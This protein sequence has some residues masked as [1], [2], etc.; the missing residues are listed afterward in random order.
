M[1]TRKVNYL[2]TKGWP[3]LRRKRDKVAYGITPIHL[4]PR[5]EVSSCWRFHQWRLLLVEITLIEVES[6]HISFMK[7]HTFINEFV[8]LTWKCKLQTIRHL[9]VKLS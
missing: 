1:L 3:A 8:V 2:T 9:I 4:V 6:L 7:S 5:M